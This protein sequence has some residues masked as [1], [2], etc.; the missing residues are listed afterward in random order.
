MRSRDISHVSLLP[1]ISE[2]KFGPVKPLLM[3]NFD[4]TIYPAYVYRRVFV[5][6]EIVA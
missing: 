1:F 4:G 2:V 5:R 6:Y 3:S